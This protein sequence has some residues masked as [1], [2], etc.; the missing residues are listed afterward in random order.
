MTHSLPFDRIAESYDET[1]GG[2]DRGRRF[3]TELAR[4]LDPAL[5]LLEVGVGTGV[6]ALGLTELGYGVVGVD[7]SLPM[8]QAA[9]RRV[10][11]RILQCD[12]R[13]LP[14]ADGSFDQAYSA[15]VL[16]VVGDVPALAGS[17]PVSSPVR[18]LPFDESAS[19]GVSTSGWSS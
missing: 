2:E 6:V 17:V 12:A 10:G 16:H 14:F 3:A 13:R 18:H 4:F 9:G 5:P 11:A 7:L 1:R 15:C 8:L 19:G